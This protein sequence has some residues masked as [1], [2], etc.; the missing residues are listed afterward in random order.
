MV[1]INV[2]ELTRLS[3]KP[4]PKVFPPIRRILETFLQS[5]HRRRQPDVDAIVLSDEG[6]IDSRDI[7]CQ[8]RNVTTGA[9]MVVPCGGNPNRINPCLDASAVQ[10]C[11]G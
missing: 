8:S 9:F 11:L 5:I 4:R 3:L 6:T 7:D 10:N 2:R 1:I